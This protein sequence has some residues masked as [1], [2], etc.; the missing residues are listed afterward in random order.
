MRVA[1]FL[2]HTKPEAKKVAEEILAFFREKGV[3]VYAEEE[4]S[5]ILKTENLFSIDPLEIDFRISL[6]GDGTILRL[7]HRHPQIKAPLVGVNLG[8]LGFLADIPTDD[9]QGCLQNLIDGNFDV[10]ER[11]VMEGSDKETTLSIAVNNISFHRAHNPSLIELAVHVD[12]TYLNTF[13]ADGLII[14]TPTGSTAYNLAAGGPIL[15]PLLEA[16]VLTPICP[17]TIS[18]RPLVLFPKHEIKVEY[19]SHYEP[20]EVS[21]DGVKHHQLKTNESVTIRPSQ[22]KFPLLNFKNHDYFSTLRSKLN[23]SGKLRLK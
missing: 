1:L 8:G 16:C 5:K 19:I 13:S 2:N 15:S 22:M 6:G 12:G 17:H 18:N 7:V 3:T 14:A 20:I 11:I 21:F 9:L 4:E 23:W 10:Q